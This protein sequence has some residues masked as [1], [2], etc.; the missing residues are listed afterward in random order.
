MDIV[1]GLVYIGASSAGTLW[2]RL[3]PTSHQDL[4]DHLR[5]QLGLVCWPGKL[6][7][8]SVSLTLGWPKHANPACFVCSCCREQW[9]QWR[10]S[11]CTVS[12]HSCSCLSF[13]FRRDQLPLNKALFS[14]SRTVLRPHLVIQSNSFAPRGAKHLTPH[15]I[16]IGFFVGWSSQGHLI[17]KCLSKM[18]EIMVWDGRLCYSIG[19]K[20]KP[21]A[22]TCVLMYPCQYLNLGSIRMHF[23]CVEP[24][25]CLCRCTEQWIHAAHAV[26]ER[27]QALTQLET[28]VCWQQARRSMITVRGSGVC[29]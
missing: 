24:G 7:N 3:I 14:C 23:R 27:V 25:F 16:A 5:Q 10:N 21:I 29:K 13:L 17:Q 28:E 8:P 11:V 6:H 19:F 2:R 20:W 15:V 4:V 1:P 18:L 12:H 9:G 22:W 26:C